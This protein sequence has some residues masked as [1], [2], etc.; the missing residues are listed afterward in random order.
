M[1]LD[2]KA[3]ETNEFTGSKVAAITFTGKLQKADYHRFIPEIDRLIEERGKIRIFLQLVDFRGWSAGALWEDVK[4]DVRHFDDIERLAV[5][6]E[7][8]WEEG[9]THF[10]KPFTKAEIRYFDRR[11]IDEARKWIRS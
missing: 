1:G 8:Q 11:K 4:F 6:G 5:V 7:H 10:A 9:L 3:M 2:L